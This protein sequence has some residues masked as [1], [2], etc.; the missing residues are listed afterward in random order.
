MQLLAPG[1][2]KGRVTYQWFTT[3]GPAVG[4]GMARIIVLQKVLQAILKVGHAGKAAPGQ[5]TA[6]QDTKEE[7]RLIEPRAM[8]R[9]KVEHVLVG[10]IAQKGPPLCSPL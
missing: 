2:T 7:F 6:L 8:F 4:M 10:G 3:I 9:S 1:A 5:K